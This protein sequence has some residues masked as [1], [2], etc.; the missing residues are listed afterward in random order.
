MSRLLVLVALLV[1][2]LMA[3]SNSAASADVP[4]VKHVFIVVLENQSESTTFGSDTE[5]PYLA[6][7]L[8]SEGAFIPNYYGIAHE[9]LPN[10]IA[11]ISGQAPT[12]E[13]QADCQIYHDVLPGLPTSNGQFIGTGCVYPAGVG[14][15]ATQLEG[16]GFTWRGYMQDM[17]SSAPSEPA[18]CRHPSLNT[19][20]STQSARANDQYAAR[21][22]PFVYF[23]GITDL[24]TCQQNDVD[25][26][27]LA[28]D[29]GSKSTTPSYAFITP[30]LCNDGHDATC[31]DGGPGGC[32]RRTRSCGAS[33][34]RSCARRRTGT[35]GSS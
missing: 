24:P 35:M 9:S 10:Y 21:H 4:H 25:L 19:R 31:A 32:R 8:K 12:L 28:T 7:T 34:P 16:N 18:T 27:H 15:V 22:N 23:H 26:S 14:T 13:N 33:C 30:D 3:G 6:D 5:I 1:A 17:A 29:L 11:M 20:D 2:S